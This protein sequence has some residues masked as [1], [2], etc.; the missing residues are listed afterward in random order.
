MMLNADFSRTKATQQT[1]LHRLRYPYTRVSLG[2]LFGI[3]SLALY[4]GY[5]AGFLKARQEDALFISDTHA[6]KAASP[7]QKENTQLREKLINIERD[8][9]LQIAAKKNLESHIKQLQKHNTELTQEVTLYQSLTG[10]VAIS[11]VQIK[12]FRTFSTPDPRTYRYLLILSQ[13]AARR[14]VQGVINMTVLGKIGS[15]EIR[16]PVRYV[17]SGGG[18]GLSYKLRHL[19]ELTGELTFPDQF[20]PQEVLLQVNPKGGSSFQQQLP[21]SDA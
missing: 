11:G 16:L 17:D 10:T 4:V 15:Q 13:S 21:W 2:T 6:S 3:L 8:Y 12:T 7:L 1:F 9:Q 20:I 19:Q 14:D 18:S 5:K